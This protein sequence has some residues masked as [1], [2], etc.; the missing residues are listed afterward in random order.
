MAEPEKG[1]ENKDHRPCGLPRRLLAMLY[2]ALAVVALLLLATGVALLAG[3][4]QVTA[5]HDLWFT[6]YLLGV[7]FIYLAISWRRG[8]TVGMR[9][10]RV[11]I[12]NRDGAPPGWGQCILR[13]AVALVSAG[14][15]GLGFWWSLFD[16]HKRCWHD[17]ASNT[18]LLRR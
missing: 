13:F 3:S 7:W 10:W 4:G 15:L 18:C 12:Q 16:D 2:D 9:A 6:L 8:M 17:M 5:G 11:T 14:L 1:T